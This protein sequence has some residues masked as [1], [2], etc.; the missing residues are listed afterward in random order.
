MSTLTYQNRPFL[1]ACNANRWLGISTALS[2]LVLSSI[3]AQAQ[4]VVTVV[5]NG[6]KGYSGDGGPAAAA[7]VNNPYAVARGP[8]G[9][10]YICDVD[11][12]RIRRIEK[13]GTITTYAGNGVKGYAG[14]GGP[15]TSAALFEPYEMAWDKAG[16]LYFVE[17]MNHIVRRVDAKTR[18]IS[19]VAGVGKPGFGGDG[20]PAIQAQLSQPH[21]LAFDAQGQLLVCDIANH[22]VRK[23]DLSTGTITTWSGTG[24]KKTAADGSPITGSALNGPRAMALAPDGKIWLALREG[25]AVLQLDPAAKTLKRIAG[26]GKSG[27]TG[28]GGPALE[29]T[30][31]GPKCVGLDA[32][33]NVYLADT[34]SHTIRMIDIATGKLELIVG[35]GK[36]GDGPDGPA[37]TC[38]LARPHGVFV[39]S[40]GTIWIGDSENHRVRIVKR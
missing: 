1:P 23:I 13:D 17:R 19:T 40:D 22:R 32:K 35:D 4:S 14:D 18:T 33:G 30:L 27:F 8:D 15:A 25:N 31:S 12:Q 2:V 34:E 24:E 36:L 38:R 28:N 5:G 29:A 20:G 3:W 9:L 26:T 16:N 6:V 37:L 10:I 39:D 11:N 21:S 7:Q